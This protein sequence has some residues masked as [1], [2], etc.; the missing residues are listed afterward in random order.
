MGGVNRT[1]DLVNLDEMRTRHAEA[2]GRPRRQAQRSQNQ[3]EGR[4]QDQTPQ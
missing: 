4:L 2:D 1:W 3:E